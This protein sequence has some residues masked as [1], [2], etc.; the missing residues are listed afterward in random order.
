MTLAGHG[1][2]KWCEW[3]AVATCLCVCAGWS[4][5]GLAQTIPSLNIPVQTIQTQNIPAQAPV[6]D[7]TVEIRA[8]WGS[9]ASRSFAGKI[10][11]ADGSLEVVRN[12]SIQDDSAATFIA[13]SPNEIVVRPHSLSAFGGVDLKIKGKP[14]S[15]LKFEFNDPADSKNPHETELPLKEAVTGR[16]QFRMDSNGSILVLERPLHDRIRAKL[17]KDQTILKLGESANLLVEGYRTGLAAGD[18]RVN[19]RLQESGSDRGLLQLHKDI[20]I[21]D[22]GSFSSVQFPNMSLPDRPGA[23]GFEISVTKRRL[24]NSL[25]GNATIPTRRLDFV[26]APGRNTQPATQT[27]ITQWKSATQIYPAGVSWWDSL[28]AFRIPTV[29]SLSPL[30]SQVT[31]PLSSRDHERQMIGNRECMVLSAGA[32]QAFPLAIEKPG[33]P[34]RVSIQVPADAAQKLV[35][36]VNEPS[37]ATDAPSLRLDTGMLVEAGTTSADGL[38]THHML[39]WPKQTHSYFLVMNADSHRPAVLA[40]INLESAPEGLQSTKPV[41]PV[42]GQA[43]RLCALYLDKPLLAENFC[44]TR[45]LEGPRELDSWQTAWQA[46]ERLSEYTQWSGHN[47]ATVTVATQG[48]AIYP[49]RVWN[50]THKFDS[51]T[52]LADGSSPHI[53]DWVEL[54]CRQFDQRDLKLIVA[55]DIEGPLADIERLEV[56]NP[57]ADPSILMPHYQVGLDGRISK[58]NYDESSPDVRKLT[59]YNPLDARV[60]SV[61]TRIVKEVTERYG[62]HACFA[63]VQINLSD[64]SHFN[65]AGD[66][67]G[68]DADSLARFER[69]LGVTLPKDPEERARLLR[70]T[71]R[72]N[73]LNHR[74]GLLQ[75]FYARLG[76]EIA[77]HKPGAKLFINPTKLVAMPPA[78]ENYL[79]AASQAFTP[80]DMLMAA[81]IDC[82][83]LSSVEHATLLRPEADSTLRVPASRAWA[84]RLAGDTQL[85]AMFTDQPA[86]AI[87]QQLPTSFR[88]PDFDKVNPLGGG[89]SRTWLF[90]HAMTAGDAARR[91]LTNRLFHHDAQELMSGGWLIPIGQEESI[92]PLVQAYQQF[93]AEVMRDLAPQSVSSTLKVRRAEA[94]GKTYLQFVN[95]ASWPERITFEFKCPTNARV[96]MF[97]CSTVADPSVN[98]MEKAVQAGQRETLQLTIAA[99][100]LSGVAIESDRV[101]M[102]GITSSPPK[103]LSGRLESRLSELQSLIDRAGELNEQQTLG[104]RGGDFETWESAALPLGWTVSTHPS[105]SVTQDH[106]LPRS[107]A[108]CLRME[109]RSGNNATAW[110][111]SDRIAIPTTGRLALEVWVR[112]LPGPS[113][114]TVRLSLLGRYR[115]GKRFQRWHEFTSTS[116]N[117][118]ESK[119][120]AANSKSRLPIDWGKRPLV[121]LVPDVP[122]EELV[123]LRCAIDVVGQGTLWVDDVR[124]YGMYLHPD[125][126]AHLSG[127]MFIA[128]DQM[129]QGNFAL[130]DQMLGSFWY[131]F[132]TTYL[133]AV[134]APAQP[135]AARVNEARLPARSPAPGPAWRKTNG[136]RVNQWQ[137]SLKNR[138]QR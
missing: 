58:A 81:G 3:I 136:P 54:L 107:G 76:K 97:G 135:N 93:P 72:L 52:F 53:K 57:D 2:P 124:V 138:W 69:E 10:T 75:A 66:A 90:P 78:T 13:R 104:L 43:A 110:I 74:A 112:T 55:L 127:Q 14:D 33:V 86:G 118:F 87:V 80:S 9:G 39:F 16:A 103:D 65:F 44:A 128:R 12:L 130:A 123:E 88:L 132:L 18:Y 70:G 91:T 20:T 84:Y 82:R 40:E 119:S 122:N 50:P 120:G 42:P 47:A 5:H 30:V 77:A 31:R 68:Y 89:K 15:F 131:N 48:G 60:Q 137:E 116:D 36:S 125:E 133:P 28:G 32:W 64:R 17:N 111:Q 24:I 35:F 37:Q 27:A 115:D 99:Y 67:W 71:L 83:S 121:L 29:K 56:D 38:T 126:K 8:V 1:C 62:Q 102:L 85:D 95:D 134:T 129:R 106:E 100:G 34:H 96:T 51:G 41:N 25:I 94:N 59:Q 109:N 63:G 21:D 73:F 79:L 101:E 46:C 19:L 108:A 7:V 26:I 23:Y 45:R 113:Q 61:L 117:N 22:Q 6:Q 114:P 4:A 98:D 92:R 105:T 11:I 49:S